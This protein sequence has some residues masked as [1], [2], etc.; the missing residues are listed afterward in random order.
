MA[1]MKKLL[2]IILIALFLVMNFSV[3]GASA[4]STAKAKNVI[5]LI[6]DGMSVD[7]TSLAR[8]YKGAPLALDEMASGLV[9]TY[10][11]D[12]PI[13]DSAPAGTA[14]ATGYKSHT[15]YIGV[16]PEVA[17]MPGLKPVEKG[18]EKRPVA[19]ILEAARL[20]GKATGI[21]STSEVQH[22]TPAAFS[23]HFPS[24]KNYDAIGE[25]QVYSGIDVVLGG[26]SKFFGADFRKD[27]EDL[28]QV[29]KDLGYDYVTTPEAMKNST[30]DKLWGLFDPQALSYDLDR[31]PAKQPSLAEMTAK[32][33]EILSK[34]QDGFFLMVEG[35]KI[36]WAAHAN[37]PI[38]LISDILAFDNAVKVALD[39]AKKDKD[40]VVIAVSDH[41]NGGISI[42]DRATSS[43][44]DDLPLSAFIDPL[45]KAKLT[46]EGLEQKLNADRSNIQ[47]IMA[48]YYGITDLTKEE[49]ESI[50]AAKPGSL[51]Y[52]VGPIISKRAFIGWTTNGHT[53]EDVVLYS[54][55]PKG[56]RLTGVVENTEVA[57][58]MEKVLG[59]D[60]EAATKTLFVPAREAFE[61]KGAKVAWDNTDANNPILVITKG[62]DTLRLPV[63]KNVAELN[64]K[65]ITMNGVT[66]YNGEKTFVPQ[67][68][69]DLIR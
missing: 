22:A 41:G 36:D 32:A 34:D 61:V 67:E 52:A 6:P 49:I 11:A 16:L 58:Y 4:E 30:S 51:N 46:G 69:I 27:K 56:E 24:R 28:I 63:Y 57:R 53:G 19:N 25:Q 20:A 9:R 48:T 10:S 14:Y 47:E 54:Y 8:W 45:K 42:G 1:K 39:F 3:L 55:A 64:G 68:A 38:G 23:A 44:Y 43:N 12:A 62:S 17:N 40:T 2:S 59:V 50:K 15:G 21:I 26:G 35:S 37:D 65:I 31:D 29:I 13:A 18:E 7:G 66:V 60:L 5:L 33:I